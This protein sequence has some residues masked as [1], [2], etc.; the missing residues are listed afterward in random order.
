MNT[1]DHDDLA[2]W[3]ALEA[4]DAV[5]PADRAVVDRLAKNDD[6]A[7]LVAQYRDTFAEM[8][9]AY[10]VEPGAQLRTDVLAAVGDEA[11]ADAPAH[12]TSWWRVA[13]AAAVV[14][15][16]GVGA[17]VL[18]TDTFGDG[19]ANEGQSVVARPTSTMV[20]GATVGGGTVRVMHARGSDSAVVELNGVSAPPPGRAYQM[21]VVDSAGSTSAGVMEPEDIGQTVRTTITGV[22]DESTVVISM[23]PSGGS[24]T[25]T[26]PIVEVSLS[27]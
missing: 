27:A 14:A 1:P 17:L 4:A 3:A 5:D 6:F 10:A 11:A 20:T 12:A 25:P 8:S 7:R 22:S 18:T 26:T 9:K 2:A 15:V 16:V 13:A 24:A 23:E 19:G 21:W